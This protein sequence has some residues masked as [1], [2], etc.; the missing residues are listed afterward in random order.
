[1]LSMMVGKWAQ[2]S[3]YFQNANCGFPVRKTHG[4]SSAGSP[5]SHHS[6]IEFL[7]YQRLGL[8]MLGA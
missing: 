3:T 6:L 5:R 4:L 8:K 7:F 1:M 2:G